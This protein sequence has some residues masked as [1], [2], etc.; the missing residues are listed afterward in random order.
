MCGGER[1][2]PDFTPLSVNATQECIGHGAVMISPYGVGGKAPY[3]YYGLGIENAV[4]SGE[5]ILIEITDADGCVVASPFTTKIV[6]ALLALS[7]RCDNEGTIVC[8]TREW[9]CSN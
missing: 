7:S 2:K 5:Q 1:P 9:V 4:R 6:T 8:R 3:T